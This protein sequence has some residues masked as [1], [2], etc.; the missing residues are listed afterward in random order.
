MKE[1][2]TLKAFKHQTTTGISEMTNIYLIYI[3]TLIK[4][5]LVPPSLS[6]DRLRLNID[7]KITKSLL[8]SS[9]SVSSGAEMIN[10]PP[11]PSLIIC[12]DVNGNL[13]VLKGT[14]IHRCS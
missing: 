1:K 5:I 12:P 6:F 14:T 7:H 4:V 13:T 2:K 11:P 10:N 8:T 9:T 3:K